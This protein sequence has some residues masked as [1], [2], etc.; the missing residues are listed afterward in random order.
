MADDALR[1]AAVLALSLILIPFVG[2]EFMP[3]LDEGGLWVRAT[4]PYKHH[5]L[6]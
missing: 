4:M 1:R 5:L 2:A 6:R 3:H